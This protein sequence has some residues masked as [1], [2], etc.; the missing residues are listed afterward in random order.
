MEVDELRRRLDRF[1]GGVSGFARS[2][3][4]TRRSVYNWL[5]GGH[6]P[7]ENLD[8]IEKVLRLE[9][10]LPAPKSKVSP[11]NMEK[12]RVS[13]AQF[14]YTDPKGGLLVKK[15]SLSRFIKEVFP[16]YPIYE[17]VHR[18]IV[19]RLETHLR[20]VLENRFERTTPRKRFDIYMMPPGTCKTTVVVNA[21]PIWALGIEPNLRFLVASED[22][23]IAAPKVDKC[24][25][26]IAESAE[27]HRIFPGRL[28]NERGGRDE[29]KKKWTESAFIVKGRTEI[30]Q[31]PSMMA[32]GYRNFA[33]SFHYDFILFDD[34][35]AD[36]SMRVI[37]N[38]WKMT[39]KTFYRMEPWGAAVG[40]C[41]TWREW[42]WSARFREKWSDRLTYPPYIRPLDIGEENEYGEVVSQLPQFWSNEKATQEKKHADKYD[43]ACQMMLAPDKGGD[44]RF[45]ASIFERSL[46]DLSDVTDVR[47]IMMT[48]DLRGIREEITVQDASTSED[49]LAIGGWRPRGTP[50]LLDC[51]SGRW[52]QEMLLAKIKEKIIL[53]QPEILGIED[54]AF[55]DW[56]QRAIGLL[57]DE[58]RVHG[59]RVPMLVPMKH[60]GKK[61]IDRI[62]GWLTDYNKGFCQFSN[63]MEALEKFREQL[64]TFPGCK[65][66]VMDLLDVWA[67][68]LR[69][70]IE[71][72]RVPSLSGMPDEI[73]EGPRDQRV[74]RI[75]QYIMAKKMGLRPGANQEERSLEKWVC[76]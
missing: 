50:V 7:E 42:D 72:G 47:E 45:S 57:L 54:V 17:A 29:K 48:A 2:Y 24:R 25:Q 5:N 16:E 6:I 58:M 14:E 39:E 71:L 32:C 67:Y 40:I 52:S 13:E 53:W 10:P 56:G 34:P 38:C 20:Y 73:S 74:M 19:A 22:I 70:S 41:T 59:Y 75:H 76:G 9:G 64:I 61:K 30:H 68:L 26:I 37:D 65:D 44:R 60:G 46:V 27:Y 36:Q 15:I 69:L 21:F 4:V 66:G 1:P 49:A 28:P 31:E 11:V 35:H 51:A 62:R 8:K 3:G 43:W 55:T 12:L 18:E 33:A 63:R 23:D